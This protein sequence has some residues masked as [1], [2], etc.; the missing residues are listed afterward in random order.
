[1]K[2]NPRVVFQ[3]RVKHHNTQYYL[4]LLALTSDGLKSWLSQIRRIIVYYFIGL[5]WGLIELTHICRWIYVSTR[6]SQLSKADGLPE[7]GWVLAY[8][9]KISPL[10]LTSSW[11]ISLVLPSDSTW[12]GTISSSLLGCLLANCRSWDFS[13]SMLMGASPLL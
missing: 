10:C 4:N 13:A 12:T 1:M 6:L 7:C 3:G 8:P 11:D 9:L 5:L 2:E